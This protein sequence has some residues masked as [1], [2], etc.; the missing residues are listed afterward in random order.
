M[1]KMFPF[2]GCLQQ[3][4]QFW[5]TIYSGVLKNYTNENQNQFSEGVK[6]APKVVPY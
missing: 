4:F 6:K 3:V 2:E 1:N 5:M